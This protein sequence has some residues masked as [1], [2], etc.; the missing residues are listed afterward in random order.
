MALRYALNAPSM[1][2]QCHIHRPSTSGSMEWSGVEI[3]SQDV[4]AG[5]GLGRIQGFSLFTNHLRSDHLIFSSP[6]SI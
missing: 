6:V 3:R 1:H 4:A 2:N 5:P